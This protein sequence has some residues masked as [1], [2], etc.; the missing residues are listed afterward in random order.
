MSWRLPPRLRRIRWVCPELAGMGATPASMAKASAERKR[1]TSPTSPMSR[2]A[3]STPIPG[4]RRSGWSPTS[5][6]SR[7]SSAF[8]RASQPAQAG[9]PLAGELGLD[10]AQRAQQPPDGP[11][12]A[13]RHQVGG[14]GA[15]AG[16]QHDEVGVESV[17]HPG[18]LGDEVLARLEQELDGA[19]RIGQ[20]DRRQV[21]LAERSPGR[22][23][24]RHR[25]RS[26]R[27]G[28]CA[29]ARDG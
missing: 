5:A 11:A 2:A 8:D 22:S 25:D 19:C 15:I 23:R 27:P 17:A 29:A 6:A 20:A 12:V 13:L 24:G 4:S 26:C 10:A 14:P 28:G 18:R 21:G 9:Q 3:T 16:Q 7:S 1:R